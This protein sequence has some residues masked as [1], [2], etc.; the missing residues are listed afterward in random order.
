M[1]KFD[2]IEMSPFYILIAL[3]FLCIDI[4][5]KDSSCVTFSV[6]FYASRASIVSISSGI[7]AYS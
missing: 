3:L 4:I 2:R 7:R 1:P 5:L 6:N